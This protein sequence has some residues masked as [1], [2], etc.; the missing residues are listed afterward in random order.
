MDIMKINPLQQIGLG[1]AIGMIVGWRVF[2]MVCTEETCG[3]GSGDVI[4]LF[5]EGFMIASGLLLL[6]SMYELVF[7][8][9]KQGTN[10][11]ALLIATMLIG[12][13]VVGLGLKK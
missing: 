12:R 1:V 6:A 11:I 10:G 4:L 7:S 13:I 3:E 5:A 8:N 9:R 2:L